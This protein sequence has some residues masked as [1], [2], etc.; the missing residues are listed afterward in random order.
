M[1]TGISEMGIAEDHVDWF[2]EAVRPLLVMNFNHGLKHST[3][4]DKTGSPLHF[5]DK[6][7]DRVK[8]QWVKS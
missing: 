6:R 8:Y 1:A 3:E 4:D 7:G 2:L 5:I